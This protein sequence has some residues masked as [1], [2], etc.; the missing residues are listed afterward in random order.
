MSQLPG[1]ELAAAW[2]VI[3]RPNQDQIASEVGELLA[4]LHGLD[5]AHGR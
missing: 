2:P 5:P 3:P 4:A 1:T